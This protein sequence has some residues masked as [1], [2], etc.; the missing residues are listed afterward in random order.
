MPPLPWFAVQWFGRYSPDGRHLVFD[1]GRSSPALLVGAADGASG[2]RLVMPLS[3]LGCPDPLHWEPVGIRLSGGE[4]RPARSGVGA[5]R[6]PHPVRDAGRVAE[7]LRGTHRDGLFVVDTAGRGLRRVVTVPDG[8]SYQGSRGWGRSA[9]SARGTIAY[10]V[11]GAIYTVRPDGS[12][13]RRLVSGFAPTWSPTGRT[14]AYVRGGSAGELD[15][16]RSD[17]RGRRTVLTGAVAD[18]VWSPDGH[19]ILF[20]GSLTH[21]RRSGFRSGLF[22]IAPSGRDL[23]LLVPE[24]QNFDPRKAE[25]QPLP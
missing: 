3:R 15:T 19:T 21:D 2:I 11:H 24:T 4:D 5:G 14:L 23:R 22:T 1:F 12:H 17:G 8:L 6:A 10:V 18:P 20:H 16:V 13:R 9:W 7:R 25:W